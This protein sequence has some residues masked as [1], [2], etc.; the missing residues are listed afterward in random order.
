MFAVPSVMLRIH[1][2]G[3]FEAPAPA[4]AT[5]RG[6]ALVP[7]GG[8][9]RVQMWYRKRYPGSFLGGGNSFFCNYFHSYL[10]QMEPNLT[11]IAA[12]FWDGW[13]KT[14]NQVFLF[15]VSEYSGSL[16]TG[17]FSTYFF[18]TAPTTS[19]TTSG[20]CWYPNYPDGQK[21]NGK[22]DYFCCG[23]DCIWVSPI[24]PLPIPPFF[25]ALVNEGPLFIV[26]LPS[27]PPLWISHS[28]DV[29]SHKSIK[30]FQVESWFLKES[31]G[32]LTK[33]LFLHIFVSTW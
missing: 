25:H 33:Q 31:Q 22:I 9:L 30:Y 11:S 7:W 19:G 8:I 16:C 17:V 23:V 29:T 26:V 14:T 10:G 5:R 12:Y 20:W 27:E 2:F 21:W 18:W 4:Q 6:E 32:K 3:F 13:W 1:S 28:E 24:A 15:V